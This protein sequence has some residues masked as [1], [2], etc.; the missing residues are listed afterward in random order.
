MFLAGSAY[1]STTQDKNFVTYVKKKIGKIHQ[2]VKIIVICLGVG[3]SK[4]TLSMNKRTIEPTMHCVFFFYLFIL[5]VWST[6]L[7]KANM[8]SDKPLQTA[9]IFLYRTF[10]WNRVLA[11]CMSWLISFLWASSSCKER[12]L[13]LQNEKFFLPT[14]GFE[15]TTPGFGGQRRNH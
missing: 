6:S 7:F 11:R 2:S 13:D 3:H 4:K 15:L 1:S 8:N 10:I 14:A 12:K 5:P 9:A